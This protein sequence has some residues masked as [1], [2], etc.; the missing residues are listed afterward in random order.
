[1]CCDLGRVPFKCHLTQMVRR[2][3]TFS[4]KKRYDGGRFNILVSV[5]R[6]WVGVQF[7]EE[8]KRYVTLEWPLMVMELSNRFAQ[9]IFF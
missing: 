5:T 2:G 4:G 6:G 1:M 7:Q 9:L 8:E 3:V